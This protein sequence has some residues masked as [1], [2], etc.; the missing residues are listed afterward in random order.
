MTQYHQL[1]TAT[2]SQYPTLTQYTG[3]SSRNAQL[4]Q[5]DL[6][7]NIIF[8]Q[9]KTSQ[10]RKT[11]TIMN[12]LNPDWKLVY[13]SLSELCDNDFN[14]MLKVSC[15]KTTEINF[16]MMQISCRLKSSKTQIEIFH[17]SSFRLTCGTRTRARGTT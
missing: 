5:L 13:V 11:E 15:L 3:S 9:K 10:I 6:V 7:F 4:S 16:D 2:A 17:Q 14:M 8:K 12:N 1:P